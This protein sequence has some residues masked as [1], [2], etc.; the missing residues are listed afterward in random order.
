MGV[1]TWPTGVIG[2]CS[3]GRRFA[4]VMLYEADQSR[5]VDDRQCA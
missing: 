4:S 3:F 1:M 2:Q 5:I